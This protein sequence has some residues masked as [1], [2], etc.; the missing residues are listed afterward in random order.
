M[1]ISI[2]Y[3]SMLLFTFGICDVSM[4]FFLFLRFAFARVICAKLKFLLY[5]MEE[6]CFVLLSILLKY[7]SRIQ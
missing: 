1:L 5:A 3:Y 6:V 2:T 7:D 4:L